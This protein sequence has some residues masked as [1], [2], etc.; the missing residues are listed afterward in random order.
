MIF[1]VPYLI[2]YIS[3]IA[4]LMPGDIIL[5]GSPKKIDDQPAPMVYLKAGD[6]ISIEIEGIGE[7]SNQTAQEEYPDA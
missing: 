2:S 4:T 7:L 1:S 6:H 3:S 5:T